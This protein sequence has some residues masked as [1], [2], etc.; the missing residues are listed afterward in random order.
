MRVGDE[1]DAVHAFEDELARGIVEDLT[2]HGVEVEA[3]LEAAHRAEFERH[4]VEEE[5][6]VGLSRKT[7]QLAFSRGR[8]RIVDVLQVGRLAAQAG[9]VI[10]DLAVDLA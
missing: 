5:C 7:D 9:A 8:S 1:D 6:A 3:R 4:E 10:D 2:G